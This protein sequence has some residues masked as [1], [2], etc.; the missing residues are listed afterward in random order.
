L[1]RAAAEGDSMLPD[2]QS[3]VLCDDI[4]QERN[5]KFIL[6]GLFDGLAVERFPATFQRIC[7]FN[8]WCCGQG[9]FEQRSRIVA[10]DGSTPVVHGK[11]VSIRLPGPEATATSVEIFL[12][13]TFPGPGTYWVEVLLDGDLKLRY[14]LKAHAIA[15]RDAQPPAEP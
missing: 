14:P 9:R 4:R 11:P 1:A 2:L 7:V 12:N 5:G 3:S 10:Q 13:V 15:K 6:I 8:R